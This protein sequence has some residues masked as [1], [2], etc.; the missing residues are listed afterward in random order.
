MNFGENV[1]KTEIKG[2]SY[3]LYL[4]PAEEGIVMAQKLGQL[5]IPLLDGDSSDGEI[6]LDFS[7]L[8]K[9]ITSSISDKDFLAIIKRLLKESTA[10]GKEINFN[11]YF[12]ANYGTLIKLIAFALKENFGSFFEG[13]AT[14]GE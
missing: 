2:V 6:E 4:L 3:Q 12:R 5:V 13:L 14:L 11:N 8:A 1:V 7:K 9:N 10:D